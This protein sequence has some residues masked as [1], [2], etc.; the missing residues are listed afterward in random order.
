MSGDADR[1]GPRKPTAEA[2]RKLAHSAADLLGSPL[3]FFVSL[4]SIVVWAI[5][6]PFFGF[7]E[8]WQLVINTGTTIFTFL[9]VFL[10]QSAQNRDTR[11]LH[12]K[13]DELIRASSAR[14]GLIHLEAFTDEQMDEISRQLEEYRAN[15]PPADDVST[16]AGHGR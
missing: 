10:L 13:L 16:D 4:V 5:S 11:A 9:A 15:R 7:S 6:G 8:N 1:K 2:F 12:L 3:A 14:N